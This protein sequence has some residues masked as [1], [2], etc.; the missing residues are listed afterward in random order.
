MLDGGPL[1][2]TY[3]YVLAL[4]SYGGNIFAGGLF[5]SIGGISAN[6]IA[7]WNG[8]EWS[9]VGGGVFSGGTAGGVYTLTPYGNSLA[10]GGIFLSAGSVGVGNIGIWNQAFFDHG[11]GCVGASGLAPKLSGFGTP[12]ANQTTG[13]QIVNGPHNGSGLLFFA[14]AQAAVPVMGCSF[15]L[16]GIVL[17]PIALPLNGAG[18]ITL[19]APFP[20]GVPSGTKIY[21]QFIAL[22]PGAPN[23]SF[24]AS[25]ELLMVA[26]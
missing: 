20:V 25:N 1:G 7:R 14:T 17:S 2:G 22:D 18:T 13:I 4:A 16:G 24:S 11:V 8:S 15:L 10:A 26:Q 23:G 9:V 21:S 12:L 6:G 19:S 5:S 3:P